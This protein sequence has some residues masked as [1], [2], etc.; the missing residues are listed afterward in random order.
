MSEP[1]ELSAAVAIGW[2]LLLTVGLVAVGVL[3]GSACGGTNLGVVVGSLTEL[4]LMLPA[5]S[6][7]VRLYGRGE[8]PQALALGSVSPIELAIGASLGVSL[9]V[10]AGY[11]SELVERRFPTPPEQLR[12]ELAML[13]PGSVPM[14]LAMLLCVAV[15]VP[16]CEELFFRGALFT[17]L[18]R[19]GPAVVAMWT[20]S[21]AFVLAHQQPRNWPPLLLVALALSELRRASGSI[22]PG[23][24]LHAAF[25]G[26]TL[27]VV[28]LT[29][30]MDVKSQS[31]TW[32]AGLVGAVGC[33]LGL[34]LFARAAGRRLREE[35]TR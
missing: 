5:A 13:T 32:Q 4:A 9:H 35:R 29:K 22:W 20:T 25:N 1:R 24:S 11:L 14:A 16:Y 17:P 26:A 15:L 19:T 21:I 30:P 10:P 28:F 7:L 33:G 2:S 31:G 34:W 8:R 18:L 12:A 6:F 3:V 23:I 27:L